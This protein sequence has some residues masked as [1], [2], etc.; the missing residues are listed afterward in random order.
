[1]SRILLDQSAPLGLRRILTG[2]EVKTAYEMGWDRMENGRLLDA[3]EGAG[4]DVLVSSDQS[5]WHQQNLTGR[6]IAVV[7]LTTNH[8]DTI[9][10]DPSAAVAACVGAG[11]GSYTV[12]RFPLPP[13]RPPSP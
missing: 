6:R 13:R 11:E 2:H 1:L 9:R 4:F 10:A 7:I 12:V 5:L 3:A 8:W